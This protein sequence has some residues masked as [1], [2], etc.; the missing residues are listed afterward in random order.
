MIKRLLKANGTLALFDQGIVSFTRFFTS[1]L[2]GRLCG[3]EDLGIYAFC[4]T[5]LLL[6]LSVQD[7]L[8]TKPYTMLRQTQ[9][10]DRSQEYLGSI[11]HQHGLLALTFALGASLVGFIC[12]HFELVQGKFSIVILILAIL[13]PFTL[14]W[15]LMRRIAFA[16]FRMFEAAVL[17]AALAILQLSLLL[18]LALMGELYL[19]LAMVGIPLATAIIGTIWFALWRRNFNADIRSYRRDWVANWDFGRWILAGQLLG[20]LHGYAVPWVLALTVGIASTGIFVAA[21]T[22]IL[23]TNPMVLGLT[24][25]LEPRAAQVT[26]TEG[27]SGLRDLIFKVMVGVTGLMSAFALVFMV[28][29]PFLLEFVFGADYQG[30]GLLVGIFGLC[31]VAWSASSVLSSGLVALQQSRTV[32]WGSIIGFVSTLLLVIPFSNQ[33]DL[34]GAAVALLAGSTVICIFLLTRF[35]QEVSRGDLMASYS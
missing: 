11:L 15:D 18:I 31:P 23:L 6:A 34:V 8:I 9:P 4:F 22:I 33:W 12:A 20:T 24:N 5:I 25:W 19:Y 7:S 14:F 27:P 28:L 13:V 35:V 10:G 3:P 21:Q 2:I 17:D 26:A 1:V 30:Y 29:G 16:H 32:F